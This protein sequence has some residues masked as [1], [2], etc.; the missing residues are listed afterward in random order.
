M[1]YMQERGNMFERNTAREKPSFIPIYTNIII[2]RI[3][4]N[5]LTFI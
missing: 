1:K 4:L 3:Y 5:I 2:I